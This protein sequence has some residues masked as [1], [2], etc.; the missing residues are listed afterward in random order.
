MKLFLCALLIFQNMALAEDAASIP[1]PPPPAAP[2]MQGTLDM[3][4]AIA[5]GL[6]FSPDVQKAKSVMN[7]SDAN[8]RLA[9]SALFPTIKAQGLTR[10]S[11]NSVTYDPNNAAGNAELYSLYNEVYTAQ[12][13]A[14]Q[15]LY[16]G[17]KLEAGLAAGRVEQDLAKQKYFKAKQ[18]YL[19]QLLN[20]YYDASSNAQ[21]LAM[22]QLNRDILKGYWEVTVKYVNIGRSKGI[23]RLQAEANLQLAEAEILRLEVAEETSVQTLLKLTGDTNLAHAKLETHFDTQ[24]VNIGSLEEAYE[25]ASDNNPDLRISKLNIEDQHYQNDIK[26]ADDWPT[27]SLDG[28][29]GYQS[30]DRQNVF[31]NSGEFYI[32]GLTLTVPLFTGLSSF[33][34]RRVNRELLTQKQK[35]ST[36]QEL[37]VKNNLAVALATVQRNFE[38]LKLNRQAA[39]SARKAM[40]VALR[41][42]RQGLLTSTDVITLQNTRYS[43]ETAFLTAQFSYLQ[44]VLNLRHDLGTDLEKIYAK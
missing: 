38:Q 9:E 4:T 16:A 28:T 33:S 26:I 6:A 19:Q 21:K 5:R 41:D 1:M 7:Q 37:T 36:N 11:R 14:S 40:D 10:T 32:V 23:D 31:D 24:P 29:F 30:P 3:K 13:V 43:A 2:A 44:Q 8:F 17:G 12:V 35:D 15:P 25:R 22:A 39:E 27:L 18:D 20:A 42:Y 34:Q